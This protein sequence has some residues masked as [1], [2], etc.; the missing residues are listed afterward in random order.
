MRLR[1]YDVLYHADLVDFVEV[2]LLSSGHVHKQDVSFRGHDEL[3][4]ALVEDAKVR[5][6]LKAI[7]DAVDASAFVLNVV[8]C[9]DLFFGEKEQLVFFIFVEVE[10]AT[11]ALLK[12]E[13]TLFLKLEF[14]LPISFEDLDLL[15]FLLLS[16]LQYTD[17]NP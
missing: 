13:V 9:K 11:Y 6:C 16:D 10:L 3:G 14:A 1:G 4:L 12:L 15:H 2:K 8:V 5:L 17:C 7:I